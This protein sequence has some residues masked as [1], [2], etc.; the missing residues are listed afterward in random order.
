MET[1][2]MIDD[3]IKLAGLVDE[4]LSKQKRKAA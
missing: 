4:F 2:L 1:I 3:D